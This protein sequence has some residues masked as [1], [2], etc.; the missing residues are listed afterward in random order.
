MKRCRWRNFTRRARSPLP[1]TKMGNHPY[2]FFCFR[3]RNQIHFPFNIS[4]L[5]GWKSCECAGFWSG[6]LSRCKYGV[7]L[8][9]FYITKT[10][11]TQAH[12]TQRTCLSAL[13]TKCSFY[14][15]GKSPGESDSRQLRESDCRLLRLAQRRRKLHFFSDSGV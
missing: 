11:L 6:F 2:C 14:L 9:H 12:T 4:V 7:K 1:P 10:A 5:A 3:S 15:K 13:I 8:K